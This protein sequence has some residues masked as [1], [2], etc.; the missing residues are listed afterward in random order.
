MYIYY[1]DMYWGTLGR[2][3]NTA[4]HVSVLGPSTCEV[5]FGIWSLYIVPGRGQQGDRK[6]ILEYDMADWY[7][8]CLEAR[9]ASGALR[10]GVS[11]R[12]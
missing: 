9:C 1:H 5:I 3:L 12:D 2:A 10:R 6:W 7:T 8:V 11:G 4:S